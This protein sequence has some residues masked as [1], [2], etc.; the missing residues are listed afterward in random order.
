MQTGGE[1]SAC[2]FIR[3]MHKMVLS[4]GSAGSKAKS[5]P[6]FDESRLKNF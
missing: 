2:S 6:A 3:I 4:N 1:I 5:L